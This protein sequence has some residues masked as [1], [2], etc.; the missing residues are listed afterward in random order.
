MTRDEWKIRAAELAKRGFDL[1]HTKVPPLA[2]VAIRQAAKKREE[3]RREIN[4]KYSNS[5]L[6]KQWGVHVRTI[7]KIL[8]YETARHVP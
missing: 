1:P 4:D 3:M 8:S 6:A 2:V 5:A 7:E